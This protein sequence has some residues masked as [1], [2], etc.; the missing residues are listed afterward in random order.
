MIKAIK[1]SDGGNTLEFKRFRHLKPLLVHS[2]FVCKCI[3]DTI[4]GPQ[5]GLSHFSGSSRAAVIYAITPDDPMRIYDPQNLLRGQMRFRDLL[6]FVVG[7]NTALRI[8]DLLKLQISHFS[9]EQFRFMSRFWNKESKR[10]MV[11]RRVP[12]F[13]ILT[14]EEDETIMAGE[15]N[16]LWIYTV[17]SSKCEFLD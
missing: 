2:N 8:S 4:D 9:D 15:I 10:G 14:S 13:H 5:D 6:L 17:S 16:E 11:Q 12:E 1:R 7:I 3:E